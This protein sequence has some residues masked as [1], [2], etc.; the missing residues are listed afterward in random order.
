MDLAQ[1]VVTFFADGP[2]AYFVGGA[3]RDRLL[4]RE[5]HD[6]DVMVDGD[7]LRL[8]RR[9][10]DDLGGAYVILDEAHGLARVVVGPDQIDVARQRGHALDIDLRLRDFTVNAMA[11]PVA[12]WSAAVPTI[13]D[14]TGGRSDLAAGVIRATSERAFRDDPARLLRAPR[15]A[16]QLGGA[17]DAET[18]AWCQRDAP[19]LALVSAERVRDE[20]WRILM[21]PD[22]ATTLRALDSLGVLAVALPDL[23]ATQGVTQRPPHAWDVF[24]HTLAVLTQLEGVLGALSLGGATPAAEAAA[25]LAPHREALRAHLTQEPVGRRPQW[26]VLKFAAVY[27]DVGKPATRSV[28]AQGIV[29]FYGHEVVGAEMVERAGRDLR[30]GAR[31]IAYLGRV[32]RYHLRPLF[33]ATQKAVS[34]RSEYRYFRD[35][36]DAAA[37]ILLLSMADNRGKTDDADDLSSAD[38]VLATAVRMLDLLYAEEPPPVVTPP[39][40]VSGH[41]LMRALGLA[42]GPR[43]GELLERLREAAA[44]GQAT[45]RDEALELARRWVGSQK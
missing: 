2:P 15:L 10:A 43:L 20:L 11:M 8:A 27:H 18:A 39:P 21:L 38:A 26:S 33:L 6:L 41:D 40:L 29:H 25:A 35:S 9:L 12:D 17:L 16:A 30:L 45:T 22:T 13:I 42:P 31:E 28:D 34:A 4:G 24:D 3:V 14:P 37:D 7:A 5:V 44:T 19:R 23:A 36:G 1:R 32:V